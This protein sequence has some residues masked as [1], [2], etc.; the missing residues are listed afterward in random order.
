MRMTVNN[1]GWVCAT[2]LVAVLAACSPDDEQSSIAEARLALNKG[3]YKTASVHLKNALQK[4]P[5]SAQARF[6][7]GKL[8][9]ETGDVGAA[10]IELRKAQDGNFPVEEVAP[11]LARSLLARQRYPQVIADYAT[12]TLIDPSQQADLSASVASAYAYSG[13]RD[14]AV[15]LVESAVAHA[16][17]NAPIRLLQAKLIAEKGD[18]NGALE[19]VGQV[20]VRSPSDVEALRLQGDLSLFGKRDTRA[21]LAAYRKVLDVRQ[22]DIA[23][24]AKVIS[25]H[26]IDKD[27]KAANHQF[28]ILAKVA[29]NH[30]QTAFLGARIAL[31]SGEFVRARDLLT[32]LMR[33]TKDN[34]Q[35]L[36]LAAATELRLN[37]LLQAE[38]Y[39][40]KVL[41]SSPA[42]VDARRMLAMV[43]LRRGES[44]GAL[45]VLRPLLDAATPDAETL[46]LA[47]E[48]HLLGRDAKKAEAFFARVAQ[49]KPDDVEARTALALARM[50]KG[51]T[52]AAL[53]ELQ[54]IAANDK[55]TLADMALINARLR[56]SDLDGALEAIDVLERK[57]PGQALPADL[58]GRVLL[59][60]RDTVKARASFQTALTRDPV[61]FPAIAWLGRMDIAEGKPELAQQRFEA[62]L[63]TDP[64]NAQALV[65]LASL[66]SSQRANPGEV[67]E[68]LT[69]A[70]AAMPSGATTHL[71]LVDHWLK[72][73]NPKQALAAA[74]AGL[75]ANPDEPAL[76]DALGRA[77]LAND[78]VAQSLAAF[79]R[80]AMQQPKSEFAQI[81]LADAQLRAK[82]PEAAERALRKALE[83]TPQLLV[84]QRGLMLLAVQA[85]QPEKALQ[86]ARTVQQ[87]RPKEAMGNLLEG[88]VYAAFKDW[89][90]A[91]KSYRAG[92]QKQG[93]GAA[94]VRVYTTLVTTNR[95]AE[96]ERFAADW[97]RQNQ[98]E[99]QLRSY[100]AETAMNAG[101]LAVAEQIYS[102]VVR[103][104]PRDLVAINNLAWI[105]AKGKKPGAVAM[106][107]RA[108]ALSPEN[109]NVLDTLGMALAEENQVT[110][111]IE[112]SKSAVRL[113]PDHPPFRLNLAKLYLKANDKASAKAQLDELAKLGAKFPQNQEVAELLKRL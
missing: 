85:K 65:A 74:Q 96:A 15:A 14:K 101:N 61:H 75:V 79:G 72:H 7:F 8:L 108:L 24:H 83:I 60:K 88:D 23:A 43:L 26:L 1:K 33:V 20:L 32:P 40:N 100:L 112:A 11:L 98:T 4:A 41:S 91:S 35:V 51:D 90:S 54:S 30:P 13:Q 87:Q 47:A 104:E 111:A 46:A 68:L 80:L 94:A 81:R 10:E 99:T 63:K 109:S 105:L 103:I 78:E 73:G 97:L 34:P 70:V 58:R 93:G 95:K 64:K 69:R 25:I 42:S 22:D 39:L 67:A 71:L 37:S 21:A 89:D 59:L 102:D 107:E 53:A 31:L 62:L 9:L 45:E 57:H 56:Q 29:P 50:A 113:A 27:L 77:Q 38:S 92:L 52:A 2:A 5:E 110:R 76:L 28:E 66:R 17:D 55:G 12:L 3:D 16:P 48:A 44:V 36:L 6:L 106:A 82:N 18:V 19:I 84:A 86:V 49:L